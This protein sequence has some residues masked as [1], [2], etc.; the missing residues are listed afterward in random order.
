[1][2][3]KDY[4]REA[5][6]KLI[7]ELN[8]ECKIKREKVINEIASIAFDD[9]SNYMDFTG[10]G[11]RLKDSSSIDTKN[12]QELSFDRWGQ[13]KLKLYSRD[14][15]LYKLA[16][17]LGMNGIGSKES[18]TEYEKELSVEELRGLIADGTKPSDTPK[19]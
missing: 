1:M 14:A 19:T 16:E 3:S 18:S 7:N 11:A 10:N 9:I 4:I 8:E 6:D 15:A 2:L 12:V 17:Y 13:P 5:I